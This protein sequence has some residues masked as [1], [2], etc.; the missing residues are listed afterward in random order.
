MMEFFPSLPPCGTV[1]K[2]WV[3]CPLWR[4]FWMLGP[5]IM[6][7]HQ[8]TV[9]D[10]DG[11]HQNL[12]VF[13][14]IIIYYLHYLSSG[15]VRD[16][17]YGSPCSNIC[18]LTFFP[19]L[20][21]RGSSHL[22][23]CLLWG[24]LSWV[25]DWR[26]WRWKKKKKK[27]KAKVAAVLGGLWLDCNIC[28]ASYQEGSARSNKTFLICFTWLGCCLAFQAPPSPNAHRYG[29]RRCPADRPP[30]SLLSLP[31]SVSGYRFNWK[32]CSSRRDNSGK[33]RSQ[34]RVGFFFI[35]LIKIST[36]SR[37]PL[38]LLLFRSRELHWGWMLRREEAV[39]GCHGSPAHL[40]AC[41]TF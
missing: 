9:A 31:L 37:P 39:T 25:A 18:C 1:K 2:D 30:S 15:G 20:G 19:R 3:I 26:C 23:R 12:T 21:S 33:S 14:F 35:H 8:L 10:L 41:V 4:V 6:I 28:S 7:T 27:V 36:F 16:G 29:Y 34:R 24:P 32:S 13:F 22:C 17:S 11:E 38:L 5:L 40:M